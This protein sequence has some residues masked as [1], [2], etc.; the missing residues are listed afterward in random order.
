MRSA[1]IIS[2]RSC[3]IGFLVVGMLNL[4]AMAAPTSTVGMIAETQNA[5]LSGAA[6]ARGVD[7]YPGDTLT[8]QSDGSMRLAAGSSQLYLM[9]AT[10]VTMTRDGSAIGAKMGRGTLDFS[11]APGQFEV[12][13]ALGVVRGDGD[14]RTFGQISILDPA[15]IRVSAITG[16][17]LVAG[18]DGIARTIPAG[19]TFEASFEPGG[20]ADAGPPVQGVGGH[21]KIRW[22]RVIGFAVILGGTALVS[23]LLYNKWTES[24][25][26]VDCGHQ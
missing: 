6:A 7:V 5:L 10:E 19:E 14:G 11:S 22:R 4:P 1:V 23:Y 15:T 24:C 21:R 20:S 8:T 25:S 16:N 17:L 9:S 13:T 3:L 26:R 2:V 12:E 18:A